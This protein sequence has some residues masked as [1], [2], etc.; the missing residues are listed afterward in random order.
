V[1]QATQQGQRTTRE[2]MERM[3]VGPVA[4]EPAMVTMQPVDLPDGNRWWLAVSSSLTDVDAALAKFFRRALIGAGL[5]VAAMTAVLVSTSTSIIRGRLR[6]ERVQREL[7]TRELSQ[8][9]DIQLMWLPE[10]QNTVVSLDVA[11]VNRPASHVSGDFYNWFDL[12]DGRVCLVIGDVTGHGLPAAFLMAT[13]Q[14]LVRTIIT[15]VADPGACLRET[16][17]L[18]CTH[19]FSGQFVTLLVAII[20]PQKNVIELATA[21]HPPP[22]LGAGEGFVPL[23]VEP[24]LVLAVE[25]KVE[26]ETQRF[27][28]P[29]GASILLYTDGVTDVQAPSGER[30]GEH[31]LQKSIYGSFRS[32]SDIV[33]T[34]LDAVDDFRVG[35]EPADDLTVVA[36]Q[37]PGAAAATMKTAAP[38]TATNSAAVVA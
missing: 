25:P 24:Q 31:W 20:D 16:N 36:V 18:L 28:L 17:R 35:R 34:V 7:L 22:L 3:N 37:L 4:L 33:H 8:A 11:A 21:G 12:P 23:D 1:D 15:R 13:T 26:Y 29:G 30:M 38:T 6:L 32:A 9:R 10:Q 27:D 2:F 5:V 19:V 14:L